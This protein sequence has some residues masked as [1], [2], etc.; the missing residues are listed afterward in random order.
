MIVACHY[1]GLGLWRGAERY[2]AGYATAML[3]IESLLDLLFPPRCLGCRQRGALLCARCRTTCRP[4]PLH[5]NRRLHER[6]GKGALASTTGAYHFDG[7]VREAIHAL[8]YEHRARA[9]AVLGDLLVAYVRAHPLPTDL[10]VPVP[11]H[12]ARLRERGFNQAELLAKHL[13]AQVNLPVSTHLVRVRQTAQ[14]AGLHRAERL[15]NVRDAFVWHGAPPP[16]RVLLVD[17]VLTTGATIGA[18]AEALRTAGTCEVHGL[19]LA[20]AGS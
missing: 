13:A 7:A 16:S 14:Q 8:K 3:W 6:L 10:I 9:A 20:R 17:D 2:D 18:A 5:V 15:A 11:L 1:T 19:A 4:V 12:A